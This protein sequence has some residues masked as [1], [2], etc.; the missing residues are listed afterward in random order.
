[1]NKKLLQTQ[2][3][4][5]LRLLLLIG[6]TVVLLLQ[7]G[8]VAMSQTLLTNYS[9]QVA[10]AVS[11]SS[12][13]AKTLSDLESV[14]RLLQDQAETV[15]KARGITADKSN[16]Y[17]YQNKIINDITTY[18]RQ[19]G[20]SIVGWS[21][22]DNEAVAPASTPANAQ[23]SAA[24]AGQSSVPAGVTPVTVTVNL[25]PGTT[26]ESLYT[27]LQ[28]LEGNLLRMEVQGLNLSRPAEGPGDSQDS[29]TISLSTLTI[30]V[31]KEK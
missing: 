26:Y 30:Q 11:V 29:S 24:P 15:E 10:S 5:S 6:L 22:S 3:A 31:Y 28:L 1:M 9:H 19:S 21:F 13:D 25:G 14:N 8:L 12:S 2:K 16:T 17:A 23:T 7:I 18:S 4:T 20:L 27:F